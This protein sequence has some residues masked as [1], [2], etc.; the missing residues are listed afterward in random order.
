MRTLLVIVLILFPV[1]LIAWIAM[2]RFEHAPAEQPL[3][4]TSQPAAAPQSQPGSAPALAATA[5][6]S[7]P[8]S[9]PAVAVQAPVPAAA[10]A[11]KPAG[12]P[13][14]PALDED[15]KLRALFKLPLVGVKI[16][17]QVKLYD[18]Q[19]LFDYIDGAAPIFI[20]RSFRKLAAADL[21]A[22]DGSLTCDVYDMRSADNAAS[23]YGKEKS[24]TA[25]AV[26]IGDQ[27]HQGSM[28]LVFRRD[29][30]YVKLTAFDKAAEALLPDLA[31]ALVGRM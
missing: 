11:S 30:Y 4:A 18:Q 17:G 23:I 9:A 3:V 7:A 19:G 28:S 14:K 26:A 1:I 13:K 16:D 22:G 6:A 25:A 20:E 27:A 24:P 2:H 10:A 29:R 31:K 21:L 15:G 5:P 12:E 8:A